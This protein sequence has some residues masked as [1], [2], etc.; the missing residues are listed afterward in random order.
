MLDFD[1]DGDLDLCVVQGQPLETVAALAAPPGAPAQPQSRQSRLYRNDLRANTKTEAMQFTDVTSLSQIKVNG[2]AMGAA[3]ADV[4]ND[5]CVDLFVTEF[6][7]SQLFRNRC[8]GTFVDVTKQ[9]GLDDP[10]WAVSASFLDYDRDFWLDLY[11]GNYVHYSLAPK[12]EC[13]AASGELDY[14]SPQAFRAQADRLYRNERN[15]RFSDVS[16]KALVGG[17]FGPALGISTADFDNDGWLDIFVANDGEANQLWINQRDGTFR[18]QALL[19][20]VAVGAQGVPEGNMGV[21]A[22]DVDND[23]D[24]DLFDTVLPGQGTTSGQRRQRD[25]RGPEYAFTPGQREP[26]RHRF[27]HRLD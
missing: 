24:E 27:R 14:C 17:H 10:G 22:G 2:Y 13:R 9:V 4:D 8:D 5:G 21:D 19:A 3:A 23:G 6:G 18:D 25:F 15:G 11:V 7:E 16:A 1:N 26:R 20:G 12:T